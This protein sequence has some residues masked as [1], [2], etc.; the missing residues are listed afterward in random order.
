MIGARFADQLVADG[1]PL[2]VRVDELLKGGLAV[3]GGGAVFQRFGGKYVFLYQPVS[4]LQAAV[5]I[6]RSQHRLEG[7][8]QDGILVPAA[9]LLLA[10]AQQDILPQPQPPGRRGQGP[11]AYQGGAK[12]GHGPFPHLG[13]S[14][15]QISGHQV[16]QHCVPQKLQSLVVLPHAVLFHRQRGVGQRTMQQAIVLEPIAEPVHAAN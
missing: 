6:Y 10:P 2:V 15:I 16:L 3:L 13:V 11:L 4:F 1:P 5:Q 7:V 12:P 8:G 14:I 9:A